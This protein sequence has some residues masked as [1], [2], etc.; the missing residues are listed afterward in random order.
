MFSKWPGGNLHRHGGGAGGGG[1]V[2]H[3][4]HISVP[5]QLP[6][7]GDVNVG[8]MEPFFCRKQ[9][10][11]SIWESGVLRGKKEHINLEEWNVKETSAN[12]NLES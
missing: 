8:T 7:F 12:V 9:R 11:I 6:N 10:H 5:W 1:Q 3:L 4:G 2:C